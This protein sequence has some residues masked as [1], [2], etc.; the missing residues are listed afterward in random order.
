MSMDAIMELRNHRLR[1]ILI[2]RACENT[3]EHDPE[4][5]PACCAVAAY[6]FLVNAVEADFKRQ[7][8]DYRNNRPA[9]T[10][11]FSRLAQL[12]KNLDRF[13]QADVSTQT[14]RDY[15]DK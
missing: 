1:G 14:A 13:A 5:C 3:E 8:A 2:A 12:H 10:P 11:V 6:R 4:T 15:Y 9:E 7:V